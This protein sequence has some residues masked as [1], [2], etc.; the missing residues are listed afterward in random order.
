MGRFIFLTQEGS[1]LHHCTELEADSPFHSKVTKGSQNLEI[2]SRDPGHTHIGV[3]LWSVHREGP[4]SMSVPNV[5]R[6]ALAFKS[7]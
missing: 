3:V 1:V 5:K 7:Y 2:R 4:S 6:I